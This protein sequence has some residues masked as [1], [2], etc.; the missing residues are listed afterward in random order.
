M[1][2]VTYRPKAEVSVNYTRADAGG[3]RLGFFSL[4]FVWNFDWIGLNWLELSEISFLATFLLSFPFF[5]LRMT[6][7]HNS[8][9]ATM[10]TLLYIWCAT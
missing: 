9:L 3:P 6:L 8:A 2:G 4:L 1:D 5:P 7:D 10:L